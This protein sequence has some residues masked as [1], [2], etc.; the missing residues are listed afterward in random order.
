MRKISL[1]S[2]LFSLLSSLVLLACASGSKMPANLIEPEF[3]IRQVGGQAY[4]ARHVQGPI[5]VNLQIEIINRSAEPLT[6]ERIQIESMGAG[7]Y[8]MPMA[9]RP[10][11]KAIP[12]NH[13]DIFEIW[14]PATVENTILGANGPVTLRSVVFFDSPVG[15]FRKVYVQQVNDQMRRRGNAQ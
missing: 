8:T 2:S 14:A 11:G 6:V 12:A 10:F 4:A 5:S 15:K 13:I 1:P 9:T 7:A 3:R